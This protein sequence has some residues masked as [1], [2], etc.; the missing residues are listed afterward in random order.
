MRKTKLVILAGLIFLIGCVFYVP[1]PYEGEPYPE[2]EKYHEDDYYQNDVSYF[3]DHLSPHGIWVSHSPHGYVWIPHRTRVGWRPYTHGRWIWTDYGWTWVS[4]FDWGWIPYHYG[5]WGWDNYLGWYWVPGTVWGP[6]W[7]TWRSGRSYIG[8]APL[9]PDVQF[10]AGVGITSLPYNLP[11]NYWIFVEGRHFYTPQVYRYVLPQERNL[12]VINYTVIK[13]NIV[14]RDRRVVNSG[15]D[16]DYVRR[17]S[18]QRISKYQLQDARAEGPNR[19]R[20]ESVE[21]YRPSIKKDTAV[22][23]KSVVTKDEAKARIT[24]ERIKRIPSDK[25]ARDA[26]AEVQREHERQTRLLKESQ[27]KEIQD[28]KKTA[29]SKRRI[30]RNE[31]EAKKTEE[32]Q[33]EQKA[34]LEKKHAEEKLK[35]K[36]RHEDEKKQVKKTKVK[37]TEVKKKKK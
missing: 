23:P 4:E 26:E 13:T 17:V 3:H 9:P 11:G 5:R 12:T 19:I 22:K 30:A 24:Q 33:K 1:R 7:V 27:E 6:A 15:I 31:A 2:E 35:I 16:V 20:G 25:A 29:D 36:K 21:V 18:R 34:Q 10:V 8:W 32:E 14:M 28:L 37:K